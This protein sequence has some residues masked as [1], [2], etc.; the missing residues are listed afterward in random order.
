MSR[1][2]LV[3]WL[4]A[5]LPAVLA[6][7]IPVLIGRVIPG[8]CFGIDMG[9]FLGSMLASLSVFSIVR[10]S[11][12][13]ARLAHSRRALTEGFEKN[14]FAVYYVPQLHR[15]AG[16]SAICALGYAASSSNLVAGL[17]IVGAAIVY[18]FSSD[19]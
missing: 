10:V 15:I 4:T 11:F 19:D 8:L 6:A 9:S 2:D 3:E 16:A 7:L 14:Y 5:S 12:R 1:N 17:L 13:T 18:L